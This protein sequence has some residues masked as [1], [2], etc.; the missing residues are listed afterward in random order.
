MP[1]GTST[2][3]PLIIKNPEEREERIAKYFDDCEGVP[4]LDKDGNQ[5]FTKL[6]VPLYKVQPKPPTITG[7]ALAIGL[8]SRQDLINYQQREPFFDTV[9]RAK[10]RVEAYTEGRLFDN[11]GSRGAQF[12]LRNNFKGWDGEVNRADDVV[13]L[14]KNMQTLA[15][16]IKAPAPD[17]SIEDFEDGESTSM[18]QESDSTPGDKP[19]AG[20]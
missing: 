18:Q 19:G 10:A 9:T 15:E 11:A 4:L 16:V 12:S 14:L 3:R 8:N 2:G 6:G 5:C 17:R 1:D 7:L 20:G 13:E